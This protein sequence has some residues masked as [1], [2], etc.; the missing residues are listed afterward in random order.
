MEIENRKYYY[1]DIFRRCIMGYTYSGN[2]YI[3]G[4]IFSIISIIFYIYQIGNSSIYQSSRKIFLKFIFS[5]CFAWILEFI[6]L[7]SIASIGKY[8]NLK[9]VWFILMIIYIF[10]VILFVCFQLFI[11]GHLEDE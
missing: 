9:P 10:P 3:Y 6:I 8:S 5:I 4:I 11:Y 1:S 2:F 7:G